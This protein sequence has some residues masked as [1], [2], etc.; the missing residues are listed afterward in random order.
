MLSMEVVFTDTSSTILDGRYLILSKL[1]QGAYGEVFLTRH[2]TLGALRAVKRI[3]KSRDIYNTARREA[4]ALRNLR[5]TSLP[6]IYDVDEDDVYFYIIEEYIEG[7]PLSE[8]V[9]NR[10]RLTENETCS[11]SMSICAVLIYMQA[12]EGLCHLDIKP[13]NIMVTE[14]GIRLVDFGSS[15]FA[16]AAPECVTG[17]VGYA[18]PELYHEGT[19]QPE[20]DVYSLGILMS[21]MLTGQTPGS[22]DNILCSENLQFIINRCTAWEPL[23][24][25]EDASKLLQ[26][27]SSHFLQI[28]EITE[29]PTIILVAGS[30]RRVG[31]THF[32]IMLAAHF[33]SEGVSCLLELAAEGR[34]RMPVPMYGRVSHISCEGGVYSVDG[35][36]VV[37]D[38]NGYAVPIDEEGRRSFSVIIREIGS[39]WEWEESTFDSIAGEGRTLVLVTGHTFEELLDYERAAARLRETGVD[40]VS[41]VNFA[42]GREYAGIRKEHN[43]RRA[44]RIPYCPGPYAFRMRGGQL[45]RTFIQKHH[46]KT[47]RDRC[48]GHKKRLW[49]DAFSSVRRQLSVKREKKAGSGKQPHHRDID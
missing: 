25:Y 39:M 35:V 15:G 10:G 1:G 33:T 30:G 5:H 41:A 6:I 8:Y 38:Y 18:A 29:N 42:G 9:R 32:A 27:L 26:A 11:I 21:F 34:K 44:F 14:D 31:A 4:E 37:P 23:Q 17:T 28:I 47:G 12:Q 43:M 20:C 36:C 2:I 7:T 3:C 46:E 16:D 13:E 49:S 45:E 40:Y 19:V 22:S 48:R 24:R